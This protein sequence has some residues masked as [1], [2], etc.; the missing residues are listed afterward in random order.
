MS[1]QHAALPQAQPTQLDAGK[2]P[3]KISY[4][5]Q[6]EPL[7]D[8]ACEVRG[9]LP[10]VQPGTYEAA[11]DTWQTV[12]LFG[13]KSKKLILWFTL[14]SPGVMGTR[15]PRYYNIMALNGQPRARGRFRVGRKSDFLRDYC[16]LFGEPGRYDRISVSK[17]Q[18]QRF[19]V[20][21]RTVERGGNQASIPD[22][23]RYSVIGEIKAV[24][25]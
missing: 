8:G 4:A 6:N 16:R 9:D 7:E 15:L 5:F 2:S 18:N 19:R 20:G 22:C 24:Q 3:P 23:L 14:L 10:R 17:F 1:A 13:G 25:E 21:V 12:A 11:F